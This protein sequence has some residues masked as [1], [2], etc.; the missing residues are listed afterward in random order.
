MIVYAVVYG[1][2]VVLTLLMYYYNTIQCRNIIRTLKARQEVASLLEGE[3][4]S[5]ADELRSQHAKF[6][7]QCVND[8]FSM[9]GKIRTEFEE[10]EKL[11]DRVVDLEQRSLRVKAALE[12]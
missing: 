6:E 10:R 12:K 1:V 9:E 2:L 7:T 4:K 5:L 3:I 8:F 11:A